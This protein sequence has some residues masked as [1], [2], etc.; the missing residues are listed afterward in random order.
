K[1]VGR[2]VLGGA[3][4]HLPLSVN[5]AGVIP[6]IFAQSIMFLPSTVA[7]LFPNTDWVQNLVSVWLAP[8]EFWYSIIY[9]LIIVFF[10]YFYTAIV[11]NPVE[12][13]G[14][15]RKNG[16]YIPGIRPGKNTAEYLETILTRITLPG[17]LFFAAIAILPWV[18]ISRA[19]VNFFF[20]GTGLLIVV[21]VA[22]D[23]L[24]QI[25]SHLL[26]RHYD[27]F[28]KKGKIRGRSM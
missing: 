5:S 6:I 20:G 21:G 2:K 10:G 9:G 24:Q 12:I 17:A 1:V 16:G 14:N 27:G 28:M 15:M 3:S 22:L 25:E 19:N 26:M 7:Q 18:L 8:G 13:A 23:T 4:T 11:F